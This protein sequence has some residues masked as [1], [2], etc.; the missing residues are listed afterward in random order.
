MNYAS[1][2][3]LVDHAVL[4]PLVDSATT[5]PISRC[6]LSHQWIQL[7]LVPLMNQ[8]TAGPLEMSLPLDCKSVIF[9]APGGGP[10]FSSFMIWD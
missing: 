6:S 3:P 2:G 1:T 10:F 9:F 4:I 5:G 7:Q 8:A